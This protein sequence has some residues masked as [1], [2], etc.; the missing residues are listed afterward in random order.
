[1]ANHIVYA[2]YDK[3]AHHTL[4]P[5]LTSANPVN[6][7]R[8]FSALANN[9][10]SIVNRHARSFKLIEIGTLNLETGQ[11]DGHP[12]PRDVVEA[13]DLITAPDDPT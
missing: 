10:E 5:L 7:I 3:E 11:L 4:T 8:E 1:M 12:Q 13:I 2:I 9:T 6:P